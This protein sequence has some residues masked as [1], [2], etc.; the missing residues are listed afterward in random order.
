M[1][2]FA[3]FFEVLRGDLNNHLEFQLENRKI[4]EMVGDAEKYPEPQ[5]WVPN[6][7]VSTLK[8]CGFTVMETKDKITKVKLPS[9]GSWEVTGRNIFYAS[10]MSWYYLTDTDKD[11]KFLIG[12]S[13]GERGEMVG[14][15][16]LL[17]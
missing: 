5:V 15:F 6:N 3:K 9:K 16:D 14:D 4:L 10:Q 11:L 13:E 8:L 7:L 17:S 12:I 2:L 1:D